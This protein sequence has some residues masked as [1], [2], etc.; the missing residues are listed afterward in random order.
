[1]KN[2][3]IS[4]IIGLIAVIGLSFFGGIKYG[5]GLNSSSKNAAFAARNGQFGNASIAQKGTRAGTN[6]ISG[7][8][9]TND[10]NGITVKD[11]A[12]SSKIV[13]LTSSTT[14]IKT[15]NGSPS[16]L[17][18]GTEVT[19]T[20]NANQDGSINVESIQIRGQGMSL[21]PAGN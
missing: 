21:R 10:S 1:M 18:V 3:I 12:G 15:S 14:I 16:D 4:V 19:L 20:G 5:E 2:K 7:S 11:N 17:S 13:F 8:I 9:L 6:F